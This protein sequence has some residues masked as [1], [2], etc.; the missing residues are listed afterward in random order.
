MTLDDI[1]SYTTTSLPVTLESPSH[2][3]I[4]CRDPW[5]G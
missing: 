4:T 1:T 2:P 5:H 3:L